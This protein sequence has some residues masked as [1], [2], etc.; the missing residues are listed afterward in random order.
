M[1]QIIPFPSKLHPTL[2]DPAESAVLIGLRWWAAGYRKG[3][4]FARCPLCGTAI[5]AWS[6]FRTIN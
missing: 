1:G 6:P 3:E 2:I 5:E 4:D